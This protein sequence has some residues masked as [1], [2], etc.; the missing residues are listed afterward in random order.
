MLIKNL[1]ATL[2]NGSMGMVQGFERRNTAD[3]D[4]YPIV[5]FDN[6][7][8]E[9]ICKESFTSEVIRGRRSYVLAKRVQVP[10]LL[11][12]ATTIHKAQGQTLDSVVVDLASVRQHG[13]VYVALSRVR[14]MGS[15]R[16]LNFD[17]KKIWV[18]EKVKQFMTGTKWE[19]N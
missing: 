12:W 1:S 10:L 14:E 4:S 15:M 17:K 11:G 7:E 16:V 8:V 6:G 9:L 2:T 13:Q 3:P 5:Q 19:I 18:A